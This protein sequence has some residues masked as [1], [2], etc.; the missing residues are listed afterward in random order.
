MYRKSIND[1][2]KWKNNPNR[3]PLIIRGARQV[4]KTWLMKEFGRQEYK[5]VAYISFDNNPRLQELF[6]QDFNIKR[7]ID[8][9]EIEV[10][11]K[12]TPKDTLIIFDEIQENPLAITSLKYFCENAPEYDII[13]AGSLLG[14]AHHKGTGFPVGKVEYLDL[15]PMSFYEF[16]Q[17]IEETQLL[18][19]LQENNFDTIKI[20]KDKIID[21]LRRYCFVGGMPKVVESYARDKDYQLVRKLQKNILSDYESDFSKH[22]PSEQVERTR[23]LWNAIPSQLVKENKKCVYGKIKEGARAKD[24]EIALN[25]LIDSGLV[26]KVCRVTEPKMPLKAYEDSAAYKLFLLDVGLL[27]AMTDLDVKS[28]L[29]NDKLFND[30]N[31]AITEQYVLQEFKTLQEIPVF[32]WT[33]NRAELD[34]VIQIENKIIPVEA[35]ATINLQAKSLKS[36]REKYEPEISIRT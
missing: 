14:V 15:Y 19:I 8:V 13:A 21:L 25:W 33:S 5:Q 28:L 34:F 32:Y 17:A 29:E 7:I 31:G 4:G 30:Y 16:L 22:I 18:K 24:F 6:K 9:L 11:F 20:F 10:G 27:G 12:I 26:H 1:L 35:K 36:Y 2:I 23:L 3:L